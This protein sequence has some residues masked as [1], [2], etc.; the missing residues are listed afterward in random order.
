MA[1]RSGSLSR[2]LFS[3][4]RSIPSR[5]SAPSLPRLRRPSSSS[6]PLRSNLLDA[7]RP[8][9]AVPRTMGQLGCTQSLLPLHSVVASARLTSHVSV[10]SR[11]CCELSQGC[12]M[13]AYNCRMGL[14]PLL[15]GGI[16]T[17]EEQEEASVSISM[18]QQEVEGGSSET[19]NIGS[20][21]LSLGLKGS[22][23]MGQSQFQSQSQA[24]SKPFQNHHHHHKVF[25]C[26]FCMRKF[27]SSQALGGHQNAHK[28]ERGEARRYQSHRVM[29]MM[30]AS[31]SPLGVQPHS[32]VHKASREEGSAMVARFS[33]VNSGFHQIGYR[34][35]FVVEEEEEQ[36]L[37]MTWPGSFRVDLPKQESDINNKIDLDLRL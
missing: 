18:K 34:T 30:M 19:E 17:K 11:A 1:W 10:E 35:P 23:E 2:S 14:N 7:R 36:A 4:A 8:F 26:N 28:R 15:T 31:R 22:S 20:E 21:W 9:N 6:S 16:G 5:S 12:S 24:S 33:D 13:G 37:D 3:A 32:L 25:S 27:Y 29:M